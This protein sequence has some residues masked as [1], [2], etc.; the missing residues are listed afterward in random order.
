MTLNKKTWRFTPMDTWFFRESRPMESLGDSVLTSLF[1]PPIRTLVGAI[2]TA[3]GNHH[4]VDWTQYGNTPQYSKL[5]AQI[6]DDSDLRS[7]RV[8]GVWLV[9][10]KEKQWQ[11]LYPVPKNM[12][13]SYEA[14]EIAQLHQ[15]VPGE[16]VHC[17]LGR[18]VRMAAVPK[19]VQGVKSLDD[20][21][22]DEETFQRFLQGVPPQSKALIPADQLYS[23]EPR[24]GI[25]RDNRAKIVEE[26]LLYQTSHLRLR[27]DVAV[28]IDLSGITDAYLPPA[29]IVRLGGEGRAAHLE[30]IESM[31]VEQVQADGHQGPLIMAVLLTPLPLKQSAGLYS[32]LPG[33]RKE[34]REQQTVWKGVIAGKQYILECAVTGKSFRG[35]GWS[36]QQRGPRAARSM[37]PVGSV[38]YLRPESASQKL[39]GDEPQLCLTDKGTID[40]S[41]GYG[42]LAAGVWQDNDIFCKKGKA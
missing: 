30:V 37:I 1:P 18:N 4:G 25:A 35:G 9:R 20:Y 3:I 5:F 2:R 23:N 31:G 27:P 14:G 32:P 13:A 33:F 24:L 6:G 29:G 17:D 16:A 41:L 21:W 39:P 12:V 7:L 38:F 34:E 8:H 26:G 40:Y 11:R 36:L 42:L 10:R 15:L 22:F 28:E 19:G